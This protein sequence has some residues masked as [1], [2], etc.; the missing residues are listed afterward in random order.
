MGVVFTSRTM[1]LCIHQDTEDLTITGLTVLFTVLVT[2]L[3]I[4]LF[5]VLSGP[6]NACCSRYY[7]N[8]SREQT[9]MMTK[10]TSSSRTRR[11][12][13]NVTAAPSHMWNP[14]RL[15]FGFSPKMWHRKS[16][17]EAMLEPGLTHWYWALSYDCH[18]GINTS[19]IAYQEF[20]VC[21]YHRV[22]TTAIL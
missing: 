7:R 19:Y 9:R 3:F 15:S 5:T 16:G 8:V 18:S 21:N 4:V 1:W 6:L 13:S 17:Y 11:A 22:S 12:T 20:R 14:S 2:V 10:T